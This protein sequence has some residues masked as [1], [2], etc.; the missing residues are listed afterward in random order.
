MAKLVWDA[1]GDRLYETGVKNGVLYVKKDDGT[2]DTGVAWN[3]LT[4]VSE[5]PDGGEANPLWADDMKYLNLMSVEDFNATIEAYTYPDEFNACIGYSEL[6]SGMFIGQQ[7]KRSFGFCYRTAIG[8]DEV[9]DEYG[10]KLNIIYGCLAGPSDRDH[11]TMNDDPD[12]ITF[13]FE[14]ST[15]PVP[16]TGYKP[17][18]HLMIDSTKT[19]P[20]KMAILEA[21][22]YGVT[23][24]AF[25]ATKAYKAG[26]AVTQS[27][28]TYIAKAA[29]PAGQFDSE[30]WIEV[31]D[32]GPHLLL[33]D[34]LAALIA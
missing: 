10:Y 14:V 17:T 2:Y 27:N 15:T 19:D 6:A 30:D 33:P 29:V 31:V 28:K 25:S 21:S 7:S 22:L 23:A 20:E 9:F 11:E 1:N 5:S 12:A 34:Q 16:V 26:D 4:S 18:A 13:S 3:G 8:N 32:D 24:E